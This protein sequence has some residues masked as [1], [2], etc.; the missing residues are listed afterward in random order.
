M[1]TLLRSPELGWVGGTV[2]V[3]LLVMQAQPSW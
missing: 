2:V 3:V 1:V